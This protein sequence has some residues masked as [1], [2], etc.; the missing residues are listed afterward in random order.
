MDRFERELKRVEPAVNRLCRFA[1]LGK[2]IVVRGQENFVKKGPNIII[3]NHIGTFKDI[4]AVYKV[5]PRPVF[6]MANRMLFD[7]DEFNFLIRKHFRLHLK[8]L[9]P[10]LE[11]LVSPLRDYIV[12]YI[13]T[14]ISK[15]GTIPVDLYRK[16][17]LAIKACQEYLKKGRA[18]IALQGHGRIVKDSFHPYV[19]SFKRGVSVISYNLFREEQVK[20]PVT[21]MAIF[22]TQTPLLVPAKIKVNIGE[23]MYITDYIGNGLNES[24][25]R[26]REALESRVKILLAEVIKRSS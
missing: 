10:F 26:F 16:K 23:P 3:G 2:K 5:V 11:F 25:H 9:A 12:N 14:N 22:G 1:L 18:I 19:S 15:V 24:T 6:F 21:P 20:V 8:S 4:A 17:R 7:K 13:S